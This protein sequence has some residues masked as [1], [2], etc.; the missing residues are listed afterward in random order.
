MP[1]F[2]RVSKSCAV[3]SDTSTWEPRR[4]RTRMVMRACDLLTRVRNINANQPCPFT[5]GQR[6]II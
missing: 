2:S 5:C 4:R 6:N 1:P 3:P